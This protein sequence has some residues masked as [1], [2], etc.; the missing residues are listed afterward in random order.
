M[1]AGFAGHN[2]PAMRPAAVHGCLAALRQP[3]LLLLAVLITGCDAPR[4]LLRFEGPTMG[5][6]YHI[7]VVAPPTGTGREALQSDIDMVLARVD[8]T[9]STWRADSEISRLNAR[10]PGDWMTVSGN[11]H[12][13]LEASLR[14]HA[15]SGG[16]FDVTVAPLLEA[17]GFGPRSVGPRTPSAQELETLSGRVGSAAIT[18]ADAPLRVRKSADRTLELSA[19]APG[20]AVDLLAARFAGRGLSDFMIEI[21][22]EVRTAGRNAAGKAW[23]IGIERPDAPPGTP[24]LSL[25]LSGESASTS[26]DYREFFESEGRRYSHTIDPRTLRPVAH[27]LA[28]VTVVAGDCMSADALSTALMVLG[29]EEGLAFAEREGIAAYMLVR[30]AHGFTARHSR[31][32]T[33]HLDQ[34]NVPDK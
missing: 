6:R 8:I 19:I 14:M 25:A 1:P 23:R 11:L 29:P 2:K 30:T 34:T 17:W 33:P 20:Y 24:Q 12:R 18:L 15:L 32:F 31:A 27:R 21:G 22:G 13:V 9:M 4:E 28:S 16:A 10:P 7:S 3:A 5:T 26:G